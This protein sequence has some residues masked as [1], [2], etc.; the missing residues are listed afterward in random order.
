[1]ETKAKISGTLTVPDG[2]N[3]LKVE[4]L[5]RYD[6]STDTNQFVPVNI[7]AVNV[8]AGKKLSLM[9]IL[10]KSNTLTFTG[11]GEAELLNAR[12]NT[13]V[14]ADKLQIADAVVKSLDCKE[15]V[16]TLGGRLVISDI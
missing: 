15:L 4:G 2:V 12:L 3:A 10:V 11:A 1:M 6:E 8:P 16:A 7:S 5:N 13:N 14:K 9:G